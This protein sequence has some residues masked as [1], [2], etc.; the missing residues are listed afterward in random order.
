MLNPIRKSAFSLIELLV[1]L[2]LLLILASLL[3]PKIAGASHKKEI[4]ACAGNLK[5]LGAA[6]H[7]YVLENNGYAPFN[8][9][10]TGDNGDNFASWETL[11]L[12]GPYLDD[13]EHKKFEA[14]TWDTVRCPGNRCNAYFPPPPP[15]LGNRQAP[16][17]WPKLNAVGKNDSDL[18][19]IGQQIVDYQYNF[20]LG[21]TFHSLRYQFKD[22]YDF[23][24]LNGIKQGNGTHPPNYKLDFIVQFPSE[25]VI[26]CDIQ[27]A[28]VLHRDQNSS[29]DN[30]VYPYTK[31]GVWGG[32]NDTSLGVAPAGVS[33]DA[34]KPY[35]RTNE[36]V[37]N[38]KGINAVFVDGHVEFLPDA[39]AYNGRGKRGIFDD[40]LNWGISYPLSLPK[41]AERSNQIPGIHGYRR[42][43]S[44][45][46]G[47]D[48]N[49][50]WCIEHE[51][52]QGISEKASEQSCIGSQG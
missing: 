23:K 3:I 32:W 27:Y 20:S 41:E 44:E 21:G 24:H 26:F 14:G 2:V 51:F 47:A 9:N 13:P 45:A 50:S 16:K 36:R 48:K 5:K 31:E 10:C 37:H 38:G 15:S 52:K 46:Q 12:L 22:W 4:I 35:M 33:N 1:V 19:S 39:M 30:F 8:Q 43:S 25:A 7:V 18:C 49:L 17:N 11:Y 40:L 28:L 29:V 42:K 34:I 6:F